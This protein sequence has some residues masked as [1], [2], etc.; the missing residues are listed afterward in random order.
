MKCYLA[1]PLGFTKAGRLFMDETMMPFLKDIGLDVLNP[2]DLEVPMQE[3]MAKA[4][5]IKDHD[6]RV[7]ALHA[8]NQSIAKIN[9]AAINQSDIMIAVLDGTDVDS[10]TAA[11]I[12]YMY[13]KGKKVY[14]YR[15]DFRI[16]CDNIGSKVNLQV[17]YFCIDIAFSLEALKNLIKDQ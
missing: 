10:G 1:S 13:A 9:V 11:E 14:G 16:I 17:E 2:W 3:K 6:E 8:I 15:S 5:L 12:G 4:N 7:A